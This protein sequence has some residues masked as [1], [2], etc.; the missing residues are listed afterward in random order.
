[1]GKKKRAVGQQINRLEKKGAT[2]EKS[3]CVQYFRENPT[4]R[5][6]S[7]QWAFKKGF[8]MQKKAKNVK[9]LF[10]RVAFGGTSVEKRRTKYAQRSKRR[11]KRKGTCLKGWMNKPG[12]NVE[13]R[14][15]SQKKRYIFL[16]QKN[17]RQRNA[18][19]TSATLPDSDW[20]QKRGTWVADANGHYS[21]LRF[22]RAGEGS[23]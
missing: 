14:V 23:A 3:Q 9:S 20:Q 19:Q 7:P 17:L 21:P 13:N 4:R 22:T 11:E 16:W 6:K 5:Q 15:K 12:K 1:M 10:P 2:E 18:N 8:Q